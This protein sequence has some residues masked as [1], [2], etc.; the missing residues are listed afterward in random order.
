MNNKIKFT[1]ITVMLLIAVCFVASCSQWDTP[2][3]KLDKDGYNI[4]VR[5]EANGGI[6]AGT[7]DV[8]VVDVFNL[9]NAKTNAQGKKEI[10]LL[11]P[12]DPKRGTGAYEISKTK[13][14]FVGW[15][16]ERALRY[17]ENGNPLD[18]YGE[19]TSVSGREQGYTYSQKWDFDKSVLE[20][21]ASKEYTSSENVLTLYAAWVPSFVF[22]IYAENED[23][24]F[25]LLASKETL[26]IELPRWNE[27]T[28][29]MDLKDLPAVDGKTFVSASL[30][31]DFNE[32]SQGKVGGV[33]DYETGTIDGNGKVEIYTKWQNGIWFNISTPKQFKDN[34]RVDGCYIINCDLDFTG[35]VWSQTLSKETFKGQI[36]GNGHKLSNITVNQ[37]DATAFGGGVF[38]GLDANA[39]LKDVTFEN[40]TYNMNKGSLKAGASF[41][42]LA[43]TISESATLDGVQVSGTFNISSE[44]YPDIVYSIGKLSGNLVNTGIDISNITCNVTD[45]TEKLSIEVHENGQITLNFAEK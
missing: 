44:I 18:A 27:K 13:S 19:L 21:D 4:S 33:I 32:I 42:L 1:L 12:N 7:E 3:E 34:S 31:K 9:A 39:V 11:A 16:K 35:I 8:Y 30:T 36:I 41:G 10:S 38:G 2:Y 24:E 6:F 29:K 40:V 37:G 43:G 22:D 15:Y 28:G 25:D 14:I 23:G 45:D 20:L 5:Y 26:S 17:D